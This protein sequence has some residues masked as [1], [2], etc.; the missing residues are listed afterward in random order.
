MGIKMVFVKKY[1]KAR[2]MLK[3]NLDAVI[4]DECKNPINNLNLLANTAV[5]NGNKKKRAT[6]SSLGKHEASS[7]HC[8]NNQ[9]LKRYYKTRCTLGTSLCKFHANENCSGNNKD[10]SI[11][12]N[13]TINVSIQSTK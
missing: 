2:E 5:S 10:L 8:S 12:L 7:L 6:S 4:E 3:L 1:H 9:L 11:L 13:A